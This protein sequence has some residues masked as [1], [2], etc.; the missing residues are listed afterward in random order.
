MTPAWSGPGIRSNP[1][2]T[3][4]C[5]QMTIDRRKHGSLDLLLNSWNEANIPGPGWLVCGSVQFL[6]S[7]VAV[8][9]EAQVYP[10][11][12]HFPGSI[13]ETGS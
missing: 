4:D 8:I 6:V 11:A 12:T 9:Q 13:A 2:G 3:V 1:H 7:R 10:N 5:G